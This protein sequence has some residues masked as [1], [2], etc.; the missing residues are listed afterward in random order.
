LEPRLSLVTLG[1]TDF[2]R[3]LRFYRDGLGFKPSGASGD[4]VVFFDMGGVVFAIYPRASMATD[5]G[6]SPEG[7]GFS[8]VTLSQNV[9][10]KALVDRVIDEAIAA[11]ATLLKAGH[12]VFWGG[13][14][15]FFADPDGYT[16]EVAWNPYFPLDE[17][18]R[19]Q[20]PE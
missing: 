2:Q 7:T 11:G 12:D 18:G 1:V 4:D 15:G 9:A 3:S 20:L 17:N 19:V 13:Y 5:A 16:W 6:I 10:S 8:G 14:T